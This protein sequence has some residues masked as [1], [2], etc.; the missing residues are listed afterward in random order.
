M[1][2]KAITKF[3]VILIVLMLLISASFFTYQALSDYKSKDAIVIVNGQT[4]MEINLNTLS[5]KKEFT[6]ENGVV[7]EAEN[8]SIR[9]K[10]SPCKD[11][12][13]VKCGSLTD[14]FDV[15]VCVPEKTVIKIVG[16]DEQ[17]IDI[18]TY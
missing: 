14:A 12:L 17:K 13:C 9:F 16:K 6:L 18:M 7:I 2:R 10:S 1:N 5:E 11:E 3:D 8:N 4:V 15:A